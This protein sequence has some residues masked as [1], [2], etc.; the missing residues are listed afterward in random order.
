VLAN[1]SDPDGDP[2][3][4]TGNSN[5]TAQ[6]GTAACSASSCTYAPAPGYSGPDSFTYTISDGDGG[7][8]TATVS[9][10]VEPPALDT[11]PPTVIVPA[12]FAVDAT[13]PAGARVTYSAT[14]SDL[15]D[16]SPSLTCLPAS[17]SMFPI[18][19]TLVTCTATDDAGNA[20]SRT[21]TI[22]VRGASEQIA[23]LLDKTR[24]FLDLPSV[25]RLLNTQL[26]VVSGF[27][28]RNRPAACTALNV[29]KAL[30]LAAPSSVLSR[31]EKAE[32]VADADRIRAVLGC[33]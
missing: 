31:A 7:S 15:V 26:A 17:G 28:V 19:R 5:P 8:D 12:D 23:R 24:A 13:R 27:L 22:A 2:L 20:A 33:R 3:T 16:P 4:I 32:L 21:F 6:G 1:D 29:Y 25:R 10:T 11:I 9:I 30:V 18:G 14:A